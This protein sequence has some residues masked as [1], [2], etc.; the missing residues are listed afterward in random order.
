MGDMPDFALPDPRFGAAT[1]VHDEHMHG[2]EAPL[3]QDAGLSPGSLARDGLPRALYVN[4]YSYYRERGFDMGEAPLPA[5]AAAVAS[6]RQRWLPRISAAAERQA[7]FGPGGVGP[8][9]WEAAIEAHSGRL[10]T[11]FARLHMET[12]AI[13]I[14]A[15]QRFAAA[16]AECVGAPPEGANAL[17][18][19]FANESTARGAAIRDLGMIALA[20]PGVAAAVM[21]GRLPQAGSEPARRFREGFAALVARFGATTTMHLQDLPTWAEDHA[22]PLA[23]IAAQAVRETRDPRA[24]EAELAARREEEEARLAAH[25]RTDAGARRALDLLAVARS[26]VPVSED[27]NVLGDHPLLA[28][29]RRGWLNVGEELVRVRRLRAAEDVFYLRRAELVAQ[30]EGR[31]GPPGPGLVEERRALQA[32]WRAVAPPG[33]LGAGDTAPAATGPAAATIRGLPASGGVYTGPAR[34]VPSLDGAAALRPGDVLVVSA[35]GPEWSAY[36]GLIGAL[37]TDV[38]GMLTHAAVVAREYRI[39]AVVGTRVGTAAIPDGAA[40]TVDGTAG[41]VTVGGS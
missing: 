15:A 4:G 17:L 36:F 12:M 2:S 18:Q 1:W 32:R 25:A 23:M 38:G 3:I 8:G 39:P 11:V 41:V 9:G 21:A 34:V 5:D 6:W 40:V 26:L 31:E 35:T 16:W 10:R 33:R 37:V 14:P 20:D 7:A 29:S 13:V 27:H 28:A 30:L 22:R 24:L 19:G